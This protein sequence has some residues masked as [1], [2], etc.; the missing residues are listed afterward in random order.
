MALI[1]GGEKLM[2]FFF[3]VTTSIAGNE[4]RKTLQ[5]KLIIAQYMRTAE[6]FKKLKKNKKIKMDYSLTFPDTALILCS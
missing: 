5:R 3:P 2:K 1:I 4:R 6:L